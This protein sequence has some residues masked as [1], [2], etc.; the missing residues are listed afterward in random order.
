VAFQVGAFQ[1][2]YQQVVLD[3]LTGVSD[4]YDPRLVNMSARMARRKLLKLK[5]P[6]IEEPIKRTDAEMIV[7]IKEDIKPDFSILAL[8]TDKSIAEINAMLD[9]ERDSLIASA[10]SF[11]LDQAEEEEEFMAQVLSIL[12]H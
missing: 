8:A 3:A 5:K 1:T 9:A 7:V 2:N 10:I 4:G 12:L 11:E 6:V